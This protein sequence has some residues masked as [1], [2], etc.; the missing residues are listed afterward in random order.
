MAIVPIL[1]AGHVGVSAA[2]TVTMAGGAQSAMHKTVMI[3]KYGDLSDIVTYHQYGTITT[4]KGTVLVSCEAR[5]DEYDAG[6]P[7]H[8]YLWRS[9]DG[10]RSFGEHIIV[11]D[12]TKNKCSPDENE[13]GKGITGHFYSNPT[14]VEDR[15][16]GRIFI[17]YSEIVGNPQQYARVFYTYSDNDG[18]TWAEGVEITDLFANDPHGRDLHVTGPGHGLQIQSGPYAGRLVLDVWHSDPSATSTVTKKYGPSFLYSD[19]GGE[20]WQVSEYV[21]V[22]YHIDETR[23]AELAGGVL[24]LNG[25]AKDETRKQAF[26]VDGG[27]TWSTPTTWTSIGKYQ[28]C[29]SGF[30]SQVNE[31]GTILVTTHM[32][33]DTYVRNTLYAYVSYDNGATWSAGAE[34]W[35]DSNLPWGGTGAS[36]VTVIGENTFGCVHGTRWKNNDLVY[37]VFNLEYADA[38]GNDYTCAA[39]IG[40]TNYA[41]LAAAVDA[42]KAGDTIVLRANL[43]T[44]QDIVIDKTVAVDLNGYSLWTD[45]LNDLCADDCEAVYDAKTGLWNV[46]AAAEDPGCHIEILNEDFSDGLPAGWIAT[47]DEDVTWSYDN[48][49]VTSNFVRDDSLATSFLTSPA[50][51]TDLTDF[52]ISYGVTYHKLGSQGWSA[53]YFRLPTDVGKP[54]S[55]LMEMKDDGEMV[56]SCQNHP[57]AVVNAQ[58]SAFSRPR[59]TVENNAATFNVTVVGEVDANGKLTMNFHINGIAAGSAVYDISALKLGSVLFLGT[60]INTGA[61]GNHRIEYDNVVIAATTEHAYASDCDRVC[62]ECSY[63]RRVKVAHAYDNACDTDCNACGAE[64]VIEHRFA[65]DCDT[66]CDECRAEREALGDH[67]YDNDR[68]AECNVCGDLREVAPLK[69]G[70]VKEAGKWAYYVDDV[71][72]VNRWQKDSNGWC[73]LG[74]DGYMLTNAW[75]KDSQGWCYVGADGY[76]VTNT[77]KKDSKGWCYLNASGRM[78]TNQWIKDSQGWCYVGADG[79][80]V[81]NT[82]KKDSKGWCYLNASGRMLTN[83]WVRDSVG[84]CY[85]GADGYAV[86]NCWKK[87]SK[88]WCYLNANSSMT[89][90]AWVKD[91]GKWYYL[92]GNGYMV[93]NKT[94]KIGNKTYK[95]NASGVCTNP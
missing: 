66:M 19:D 17:F 43:L 89:K 85:V 24:V 68:D 80:C 48:G 18:L 34:L 33:T 79:Y 65:G 61:H 73:Y 71:K 29:D 37:E 16:T 2:E 56:L 60:P 14:L 31:D 23:V 47:E 6:N 40:I 39:Q 12:C 70:W 9:T 13:C 52:T 32:K 46:L 5:I 84:W 11:A 3:E 87:D 82:W 62:D 22:E 59:V 64:R 78:A 58:S 69:N 49:K 75:V 27:A 83:S 38:D 45:D 93:A 7:C 50:V 8:I 10:G 4:K 92:D 35:S 53:M 55:I 51:L 63:T 77:W 41:T 21:E 28:N 94:L 81:T 44:A 26:S 90:S 30:V 15:V 88:G 25:R 76:C 95:F 42:A 86:T 20:T 57:T 72:L 54:I 67:C 91:G 36:D 74:A 1:L